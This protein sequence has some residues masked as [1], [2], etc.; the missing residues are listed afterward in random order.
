MRIF[1]LVLSLILNFEFSIYAVSEKYVDFGTDAR[2]FVMGIS[3]INTI[4]GSGSTLIN[5]A[6]IDE[7]P[8]NWLLFSHLNW[9]FGST[10]DN[11]EIGFPF[12]DICFASAGIMY[13]AP[14]TFDVMNNN[15]DVS[16]SL[17][18]YDMN[19]YS[20]I[21]KNF[22]P[23]K[24]GVNNKILIKKIGDYT[25]YGLSMDVGV[26]LFGNQKDLF[27]FNIVARDLLYKSIRIINFENTIFTKILI[28]AD[29]S[30]LKNLHITLSSGVSKETPEFNGGLTYNLFNVMSF[31]SSF[32]VSDFNSVSGGFSYKHIIQNSRVLFFDLG[33]VKVLSDDI[34][35]E[36]PFR[37]SVRYVY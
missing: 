28:G 24:I 37:I 7:Y 30:P 20:G 22:G 21:G 29:I 12:K 13:F 17:S 26:R 23:V 25:G 36:V 8:Y 10:L 32:G 14:E 11:I 34:S 3:A 1:I 4:K 2:S 31:Y 27:S 9:I 5:P 16:Y 35:D 18:S 6:G 15:G 19:I 33:Y